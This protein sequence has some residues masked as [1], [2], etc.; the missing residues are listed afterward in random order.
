MELRPA[1]LPPTVHR[2]NAGRPSSSGRLSVDD[3]QKDLMNHHRLLA[4]LDD[5]LDSTEGLLEELGRIGVGGTDQTREGATGGDVGEQAHLVHAVAS[6]ARGYLEVKPVPVPLGLGQKRVIQT[7]PEN[8]P[9]SGLGRVNAQPKTGLRIFGGRTQMEPQLPLDPVQN[10]GQK[11][12]LG[13]VIERSTAVGRRVDGV[14]LVLAGHGLALARA[15]SA[16]PRT[17]PRSAVA[18]AHAGS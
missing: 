6:D 8:G 16:P 4:G 1:Q 3:L 5:V 12:R 18:S 17:P 15:R 2:P 9:L 10:D 13:T 11:R 7:S 14:D